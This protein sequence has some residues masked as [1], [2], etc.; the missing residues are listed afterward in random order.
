MRRNFL[1]VVSGSLL[2]AMSM[3]SNGLSAAEESSKT[4]SVPKKV[5]EINKTMSADSKRQQVKKHEMAQSKSKP[6]VIVVP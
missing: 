1:S 3:I 4:A 2:V 6:N 5:E